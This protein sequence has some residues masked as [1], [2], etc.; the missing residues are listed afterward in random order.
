MTLTLR[1]VK[2]MIEVAFIIFIISLFMKNKNIELAVN[3]YGLKEPIKVAFW[4]LVTFC[5]AVGIII[6]ALGDFITQLKWLGERRRMLRTDRNHQAEVT[7]L[8]SQIESLEKENASLKIELE[9]KKKDL[10][11]SRGLEP[12]SQK[13]PFAP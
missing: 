5:V 6:A 1:L 7:N 11:V 9:R 13:E 3:Y 10:P 12:I 4:E 2:R 8:T